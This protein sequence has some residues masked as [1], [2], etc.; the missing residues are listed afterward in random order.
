MSTPAPKP[1]AK[2]LAD[3]LM[4]YDLAATIEEARADYSQS[5]SGGP[6]LL[7][8]RDIAARFR[9]LRPPAKGPNE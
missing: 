3:Y 7:T 1:K 9:K 5:S 4:R 6:R 2:S 8:Q